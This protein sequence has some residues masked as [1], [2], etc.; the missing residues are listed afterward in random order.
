MDNKPSFGINIEKR[1]ANCFVCSFRLNEAGLH[2]WLLGEELDEMQ[3]LG[4]GLR[5]ILSRLNKTEEVPVVEEDQSVFFPSGEIW[6]EDGYRG[7]SLETYKQVGAIRCSRGRYAGRI[8]FPV[9]L[10]GV[11]IGVDARALGDEQPKWIRNKGLLVKSKWIACHDIIKAMKPDL[12]L[13]GEGHFHAINGIDKG[14]AA[15]CAFGVNNWSK[16]KVMLLLSMGA[17]E[18]CFFPD[19]DRPGYQATQRICASLMPWFKVTCADASIYYGTGK[20][21]GDL[22]QEEMDAAVERRGTIKLPTCLLENWEFKIEFGA[23]CKK[24][25]CPFNAKGKCGNELYEPEG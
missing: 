19:C 2:R 7:I 23:E 25:K 3:E 18:V 17:T 1:V 24:W 6:D 15:T 14:Y 22:T 9:Y 11:L 8:C 16:N 21:M 4:L 20:D 12:I 13:L 5:G 10:N